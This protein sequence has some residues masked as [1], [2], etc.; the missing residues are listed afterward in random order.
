MIQQTEKID[1]N[2]KSILIKKRGIYFMRDIYFLNKIK[3][4]Q[5]FIKKL[6]D[7]TFRC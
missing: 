7:W 2:T 3:Y 5:H 4:N 6:N 1:K